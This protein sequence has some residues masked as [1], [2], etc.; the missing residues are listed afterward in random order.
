VDPRRR[1]GALDADAWSRVARE[2]PAVLEESIARM[3]TT[4]S[5]YRTLWNEPGQY[6]T[7]LFVY[8]RAGAPCRRCGT[9]VR[10]IVQG[11]R[12]TFYCPSC[13]RVGG[14]LHPGRPRLSNR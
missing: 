10:R 14:R 5:T 11:G 13:Q 3:G 9:H 1:A 12:A 4:F 6:G 2:V 7:E 8:D